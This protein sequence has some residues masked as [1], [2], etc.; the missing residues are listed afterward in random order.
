MEC[1]LTPLQQAYWIGRRPGVTL[2][3]V[4][5]YFYSEFDLKDHDVQR[6][7]QAWSRVEAAHEM[8]R[9]RVTSD[10]KRLVSSPNWQGDVPIVD[11]RD[12]PKSIADRQ[13]AFLRDTLS[14][15]NKS[16]EVW[17][18][19]DIRL[20]QLGDRTR[21]HVGF[22]GLLT[23]F[24]SQATIFSDWKAAYEGRL[25]ASGPSPSSFSD[26][27]AETMAR[28]STDAYAQDRTYWLGRLPDIHPA[29]DLPLRRPINGPAVSRFERVEVEL[30]ADYWHRVKE[31]AA[32]HGLRSSDVIAAA[33]ALALEGYAREPRFTINLSVIDQIG[34]QSRF[35][36]T[37]G[38]F[39]SNIFVAVDLEEKGSF[40][41]VALCMRSRTREDL[42]HSSFSGVELLRESVASLLGGVPVPMHVVLTYLVSS[43]EARGPEPASAWLGEQVFSVTQTPQVSLDLQARQF[44]GRLVL[45]FDHV[46][47][48]FPEGMVEALASSMR[49]ILKA[50][51]DV[52]ANWT[53]DWSQLRR[54]A[55][56]LDIPTPGRPTASESERSEL[57]H[58]PFLRQAAQRPNAAALEGS[59]GSITYHDLHLKAR[60]IAVWLQQRSI[61]PDSLVGILM[62]KGPEQ[63]VAALG[64]SMAG[65]AYLPID[66]DL[67][68]ER[69]RYM[70]DHGRVET[71][72]IQPGLRLD[73]DGIQVREVSI[74]DPGEDDTALGELATTPSN[75]AYVIYTSGSTGRPK[76]VMI[77]HRS[78]VNTIRDVNRRFDIGPSDRVLALSSLS[79]DLSVYDVFGTLAAGGSI[80]L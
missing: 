34:R 57:L 29:P 40:L 58:E 42:K 70:L 38:E 26:F 47:D 61:E 31:T 62:H 44:G 49:N 14:H 22:D 27:V 69:R 72:L 15:R 11:L 66:A 17:P 36:S 41:D 2:G 46:R 24:R 33:Y 13:L 37:I 16:G 63:I 48:L 56:S 35:A 54:S 9:A 28:S 20:T 19:H 80:I 52:E 12:L 10:G 50:L 71:V 67:P 55:L 30:D 75:L 73:V 6:V 51:A 59:W 78:A 76:G 21:L 3:G 77:E 8:L 43:D 39:G 23:D 7:I 32:G 68:A 64:V 1:P 45:H 74:E 4:A 18:L 5:I 79:F 53:C 25:A 60:A 65:A